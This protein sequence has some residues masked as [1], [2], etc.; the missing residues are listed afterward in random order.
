MAASDQT[1]AGYDEA[2]IHSLSRRAKREWLRQLDVAKAAYERERNTAVEHSDS[3]L[4]Y[5]VPV[6]PQIPANEAVE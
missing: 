5:L 6:R 3:I 2:I 1:L 4:R